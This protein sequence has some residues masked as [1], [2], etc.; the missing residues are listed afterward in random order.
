M[1]EDDWSEG[2]RPE[3][4]TRASRGT[5][6]VS[7]FWNAEM[8]PR[9]SYAADGEIRTT[10]EALMPDFRSGS[11]PDELEQLRAGLPWPVPEHGETGA[12]PVGLMLALSARIT[13]VQL[14]PESF[15]G[16]FATYPVAPWPDSLPEAVDGP[17][18][19]VAAAY[20]AELVDALLVAAPELR[21]RVAVTVARLVL[22]RTGAWTG[23]RSRR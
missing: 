23:R 7:V 8:S 5:E 1:V 17:F 11:R 18:E 4:L 15:A 20:P 21:R 6:V 3:A 9:F 2:A 19:P 16:E 14:T 10:F 12:D 13:G 22:E